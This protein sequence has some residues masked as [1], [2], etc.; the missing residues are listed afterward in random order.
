MNFFRLSVAI[1]FF[2]NVAAL[3]AAGPVRV[4]VLAKI[5]H[6]TEYFTQGLALTKDF[7]FESVGEYGQSKIVKYHRQSGVLLQEKRLPLNF[8]GEGMSF[9]SLGP[10]QNKVFIFQLTWKSGKVF[11]Y[12]KQLE[13][14][15]E[16]VIDGEGW[17]L[18]YTSEYFINSDGSAYLTY[19]DPTSFKPLRR[20]KV[21]LNDKPLARLNA[22]AYKKG[23]SS[24][25]AGSGVTSGIIYANVWGESFIVAIDERSG[26]VKWLADASALVA[27]NHGNVIKNTTTRGFYKV[28]NG[29]FYDEASKSFYITGKNWAWLYRVVFVAE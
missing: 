23:E 22:L 16:Y 27:E 24:Y 25:G 6:N 7:I 29:I 1:F 14:L 2:F 13:K 9:N 17:G 15:K 5:P 18:T 8:F 4:V 28:L 10:E 3:R 19:R 20:Q 21:Y 11:V 26:V 12:N